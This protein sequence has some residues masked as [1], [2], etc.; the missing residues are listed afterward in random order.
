MPHQSIQGSSPS[1]ET[2]SS[3]WG[4]LCAAA[5]SAIGLGNI[6]SFPTL[7]AQ[8]GGSAFVLAYLIV[9]FFLAWPLLTLELAAG[10]YAP[11]DNLSVMR[12]IAGQNGKILANISGIAALAFIV[13][14]NAIYCVVGGW[15]LIHC[16]QS[17]LDILGFAMT[18]QWISSHY[19]WP[20]LFL[21]TTALVSIN[22]LRAGV[23]RW[24]KRFLPI[25]LILLI[26]MTVYALQLNQARPGIIIYLNP[27]FSEAFRPNVLLAAL[28]QSFFSLSLGGTTMLI[29]GSYLRKS[30]KV[31][32]LATQVILSD[33][34]VSLLAGLMIVPAIYSASLIN[35]DAIDTE[36]V[37]ASGPTLAFDVLPALFATL[38]TS[39]HIASL[40]FFIL[41]CLA[42]LTSSMSMLEV[43][44][45]RLQ[46]SGFNRKYATL[47]ATL[48]IAILTTFL[49][50]EGNE[51][52][53]WVLKAA[54]QLVQ[55]LL[56]ASVCILAGWFW[57][58]QQLL[59]AVVENSTHPLFWKIWAGYIQYVCPLLIFIL[60]WSFWET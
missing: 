27:D 26:A 57:N 4:F 16:T 59:H 38:G 47:T 29:Y 19:F 37:M 28:G 44:T 32:L 56:G 9:T 2:F 15:V 21:S 54:T 18:P 58:R 48:V 34:L 36:G 25:L 33:F 53:M 39:G 24:T 1:R 20:L 17:F 46:S 31:P 6:W 7:A 3:N 55:P 51:L 12:A 49:I 43:S 22:G 30:A 40:A 5:S 45:T 14:A 35:S 11:S 8:H 41:L 10:K 13:T 50:W 52:L 23:E 42:A 60:I